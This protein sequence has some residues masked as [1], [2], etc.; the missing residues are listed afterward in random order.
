MSRPAAFRRIPPVPV[1]LALLALSLMLPP[2]PVFAASPPAGAVIG[3]QASASYTDPSLVNRTATSNTVV[4]TVQQV[5]SLTLAAGQSQ[6]VAPGGTAYYPHTLTNTGNGSDSFTLSATTAG[7][8]TAAIY[9]DADGNGVPD[10]TTAVASSGALASGGTFRF[11]IA[12]RVP[13]TATAGQS[14]TVGITAT[15]VFS[16]AATQSNS[17][18]VNVTGNAVIGLTKA[19]SVSSGPS[20]GAAEV[21]VTLTYTNTG[22]A[23]ATA[24]TIV[25]AIGSGATAGMAYVTGSG[26]WSGGSPVTDAAGGD[27][28]GL[29]FD[30]NATSGGKVTA[31][32]A[33][34]PPATTG[35]I[36]FRVTI[37]A[38]IAPGSAQTAN[39]ATYSYEDG[40]GPVGP[41]TT[42][43]TA[44]SVSQGAAV[45]ANGSPSSSANGA[46]EPVTVDNAVQGSTVA[47]T[48]HAWN[49]GNGTDTFDL[50]MSGSTF[51]VGTTFQLYQ[52]DGATPLSDSNGNG[53]PDGGP[54]AAGGRVAFV[55]K[56]TLP[57]GATGG[58]FS[59]TTAVTSAFDGTKSD[60]V[61]AT[62]S[63][64]VGST[65]DVTYGTARAGSV[66]PGTAAAGNAA[67]TGFGAGPG[68][69]PVEV[70][71]VLPGGTLTLPIFVNNTSGVADSYDLLA[72]KDG[73]FGGVNDMPAGWTVV[74]KQDGGGGNCATTGSTI[75]NSG[76]VN[77]GANRLVCA[78]VSVPA[79]QGAG[80]QDLYFRAQSATSGAGDLVWTRSTVGSIRTLAVAPN[81]SG[82]IYPGGS[83]VFTHTLSNGGNVTEGD[84]SG[85]TV[86]L[87][88]S[89]SQPGWSAV[90]Y[91]DLNGNGSLDTGDP[92]VP[93]GGLQ[94]TAGAA[95]LADGLSAGESAR[96]F[97]KA[98]APAGA[99]IG[100]I[101][102]AT[103]AVTTTNGSYTESPPSVASAQD[104]VQV[105][106]GQVRLEKTQAL[107]ANCDGT[108]DA[109]YGTAAISAGAT[110]GACIRYRITATNDGTV[111]IEGLV[112]NDS[113]PPYTSYDDGSRNGAGGACGTGA[114]DAPAAASAGSVTAPA[115]GATGTVAASLG[116]LSPGQSASVTFGVMID[117]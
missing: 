107:D 85:S 23:T 18:T 17:D 46:G 99:A 33:S 68:G 98:V 34:V 51:P 60:T 95:S 55:L 42:N 101:A 88:M 31:T 59:V 28:A 66:P 82:Q 105:I 49:A 35:T 37:A 11:V 115:C 3:N 94:L 77:A 30:W 100:D 81:N 29:S 104:T 61:V 109:A 53:V 36:S 102:T 26:G 58:P 15:S 57:A 56:A 76:V 21:T 111:G 27:S 86:V 116:T 108:P 90:A 45:V 114:A 63:S 43:G 40:A 64:I 110:P 96:I 70:P 54:V 22:N 19:L 5:A 32:V 72:D 50:A 62:L 74:F 41:F 75:A 14:D 117:N 79:G 13:G 83:I 89:V 103:L 67:T 1:T 97:V 73:A 4:T 92:V 69:S 10:S 9:A 44:Y 65:A 39:T 91:Y 7:F 24:L 20:P 78:V 84:G 93:A 16:G 80:S 2:A 47:F 71:P 48:G 52:A 38:G 87:A 25:D 6:L 113:T 8:S 106:A 112:V 12:A